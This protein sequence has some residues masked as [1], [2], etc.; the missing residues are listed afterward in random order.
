MGPDSL[1]FQQQALGD[2]N[3]SGSKTHLKEKVFV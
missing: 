3:A 1:H 2:A